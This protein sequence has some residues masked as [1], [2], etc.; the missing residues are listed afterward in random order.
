MDNDLEA[1]SREALVAEVLRF[2]AGIRAHRDATGN[3]GAALA[4]VSSRLH[5]LPPVPR[6]AGAGRVGA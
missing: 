4:N 6:R 3:R 2:R 1:L 5:P